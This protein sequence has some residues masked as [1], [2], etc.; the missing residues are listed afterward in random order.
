MKNIKILMPLPSKD[1]DPSEAGITYYQLVMNGCEVVIATPTGNIAIPDQ[2]M[3]TGNG[4]GIFKFS[5]MADKNGKMACHFMQNSKA[6]N[7]P[8]N[9]QQINVEE[10]DA[11]VLP[12]GHDK[13]MREYLESKI[14]QDKVLGFHLSNKLI[15]AICHGVV[16]LARTLDQNGKSIL[17]ER[18]VTALL[19]KQELLAYNLTKW[20]LGDYYLTYPTTVEDEVLSVLLN[21]NQFKSG[22]KFYNWISV[23]LLKRDQ[24]NKYSDSFVV[25]DRNIITARW[26][27]DAHLFAMKILNHFSK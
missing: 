23:A 2:L 14:L 18:N 3:L 4:L 11:I 7:H 24:L 25:E 19:K 5:L 16:V 10:Y 22:L 27:G 20:Y 13:G 8:I 1:F 15:A 12:G 17:F 6:F 26:P 9:Y 21:K